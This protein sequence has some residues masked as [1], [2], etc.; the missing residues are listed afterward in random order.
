MM[1]RNSRSVL[2][3]PDQGNFTSGAAAARRGTP[4]LVRNPNA[5]MASTAAATV[6]CPAGTPRICRL[7]Q[8]RATPASPT[9]SRMAPVVAAFSFA[10]AVVT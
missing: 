2:I 1:L 3:G 7:F 6:T 10:F 8:S 5:A 9:P 4:K